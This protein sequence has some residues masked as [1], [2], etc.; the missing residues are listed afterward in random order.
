MGKG[1]FDITKNALTNDEC[2][3]IDGWAVCQWECI[4]MGYACIMGM[5]GS[6]CVVLE[7][8]WA[9]EREPGLARRAGRSIWYNEKYDMNTRIFEIT[10]WYM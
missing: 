2:R 9:L 3:T 7:M 8:D 4:T 10:C 1:L 6:W 5:E